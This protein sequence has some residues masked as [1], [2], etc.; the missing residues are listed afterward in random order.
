MSR[1]QSTAD[2]P[3]P[4]DATAKP[5]APD[6]FGLAAAAARREMP[7]TPEA[8]PEPPPV[9]PDAELVKLVATARATCGCAECARFEK[10]MAPGRIVTRGG[11]R[12]S[13]CFAREV[14]AA[15]VARVNS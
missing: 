8:K 14:F 5:S 4:D 11:E 9:E 1:D 12:P 6:P 15:L 10:R 13:S 7:P 2:A 3:A